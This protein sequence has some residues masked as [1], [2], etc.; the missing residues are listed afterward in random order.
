[1]EKVFIARDESGSCFIMSKK[2]VFRDGTYFSSGGYV[3]DFHPTVAALLG[4]PFPAPGE[5]IEW[6]MPAQT[7][8]PE[9]EPPSMKKVCGT[10]KWDSSMCPTGPEKYAHCGPCYAFSNWEP[11]ENPETM[12]PI[13]DLAQLKVGDKVGAAT[14]ERTVLALVGDI[15]AM[16]RK[17]E[18]DRFGSWWTLKEVNYAMIMQVVTAPRTLNRAEARKAIDEG[19]TVRCVVRDVWYRLHSDK[20]YIAAGTVQQPP[21]FANIAVFDI[22]EGRYEIVGGEAFG[23]PDRLPNL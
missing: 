23:A 14:G 5:M 15:V 1:M 20:N 3:A 12:V 13:T 19:K 4:I 11:R 7:A 18:H 9:S 17:N 2:P 22:L 8:A 21:W 10:C 16:T 6:P